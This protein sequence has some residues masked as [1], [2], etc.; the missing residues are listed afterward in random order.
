[1]TESSSSE[2]LEELMTGYVLDSLSPEE[3][4][5]LQRLLAENPQLATEE[6]LW[7]EALELLPYTLPEVEPSA[8]LH[9]AILNAVQAE[10]NR[11]QVRN[12]TSAEVEPSAHLDSPIIDA[13][14]A[15]TNRER[16]RRRSRFLWR[17]I[18]GGSIA[19]LFALA[20]GL[21]N[22]RLRQELKATQQALKIERTQKSEIVTALLQPNTRLSS[23][24]G[25]GN[26]AS[27]SIILNL[28]EQKA[29]I[30]A[31][32]LESPPSDRIYRLWAISEKKPIACGE[33]S[34]NRQG[35]VLDE[36]SLR[37]P[38]C[39]NTTSTFAVSLEPLSLPPQP[40][41]PIVMIQKS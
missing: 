1:M 38:V 9:S 7:W 25:K 26:N 6:N 36:F 13:T 3:D 2:H 35:T 32:N 20:L 28:D 24:T 23:L 27:G 30:V 31:N 14:Q 21:D 16:V 10:T 17:T 8:H 18:A 29:V 19:A 4:E 15:Q 22:Y 34:A 12:Y 5:E 41:G 39:S 11:E 40:V 33:F 37:A